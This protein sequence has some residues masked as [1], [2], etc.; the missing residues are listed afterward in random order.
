MVY[1]VKR[2]IKRGKT[3][4]RLRRVQELYMKPGLGPNIRFDLQV[5]PVPTPK[6]T[7]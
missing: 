5:E 3:E 4:V 2:R 6:L 1:W 7:D